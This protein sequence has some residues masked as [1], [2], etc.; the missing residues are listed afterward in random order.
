MNSSTN[1]IESFIERLPL[2]ILIID[3]QGII[4]LSNNI[5]LKLLDISV[6]E[7]I[8]STFI[9]LVYEPSLKILLDD[10]HKGLITN[11]EYSI[12]RN[13][14]KLKLSINYNK[15]QTNQEL[16]VIIQD[17]TSFHEI[18]KVKEDFISTILHKFRNPLSTLKTTLSI[19]SEN[20]NDPDTFEILEM[21]THEA[22][23]LNQFLNSLRDLFYLETGLAQNNLEYETFRVPLLIERSLKR[24]QG[25]L[26]E[27]DP[28]EKRINIMLNTEKEIYAD[29][30]KSIHILSAVIKNALQY[31]PTQSTITISVTEKDSFITLE[32]HDNGIGIAEEKLPKIFKKYFREDNAYTRSIEGN[33][34]GLY[35]SYHYIKLMGGTIYCES[36]KGKGS[37]F[38]IHFPMKKGA[39]DGNS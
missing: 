5:A 20:T 25:Q 17:I 38:I 15:Q 12:V 39:V 31:S 28:F 18:S 26:A 4:A 30:E 37:S 13:T 29:F 32:I 34:L 33:G 27:N 6:E 3:N 36:H 10:I 19:L 23:R 2:G 9:E 14:K 8:S 7:C 21:A 11:C 1:S 35:L 16:L 24:L 22:N